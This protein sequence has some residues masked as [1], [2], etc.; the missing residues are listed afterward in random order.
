MR[1]RARADRTAALA[2]QRE[3]LQESRWS[4]EP[5]RA[6]IIG[7]PVTEVTGHSDMGSTPFTA[8]AGP[9]ERDA[10]QSPTASRHVHRGQHLTALGRLR[11]ARGH[12]HDVADDV[13]PGDDRLAEVHA[14][15]QPERLRRDVLTSSSAAS[16]A[17]SGRERAA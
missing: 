16:T 11:D 7:P 15:P 6:D 4:R 8:P 14:G 10:A 17:A 2:L 13:V 9:P 12:V 5:A 3:Q 1:R